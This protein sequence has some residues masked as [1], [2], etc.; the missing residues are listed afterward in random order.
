M[1]L[2]YRYVKLC[3][4]FTG[5]GR[6]IVCLKAVSGMDVVFKLSEESYEVILNRSSLTGLVILQP[7][8]MHFNYVFFQS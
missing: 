8:V 3:Q 7:S 1:W 5:V 6:E 4:N 2:T